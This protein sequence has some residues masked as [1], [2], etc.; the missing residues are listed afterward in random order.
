MHIQCIIQSFAKFV[1]IN[2]TGVTF[3]RQLTK[4]NRMSLEIVREA[5]FSLYRF[6]DVIDGFAERLVYRLFLFRATFNLQ[7]I[8][9]II[10]IVDMDDL[11]TCLLV[12]SHDGAHVDRQ[13]IGQRFLLELNEGKLRTPRK[14]DWKESLLMEVIGDPSWLDRS[15]GP[16][17]TQIS[18]RNRWRSRRRSERIAYRSGRLP[19]NQRHS[20]SPGQIFIWL[21]RVM[22]M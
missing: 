6:H 5:S 18:V 21:T 10:R 8:E 7:M 3:E 16:C 19:A 15:L 22:R 4:S 9:T 2:M 12:Q 13:S 20:F 17:G 1:E 14:K 11:C